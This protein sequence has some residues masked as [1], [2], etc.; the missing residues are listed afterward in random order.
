MG[1]SGAS[2]KTAPPAQRRKEWSQKVDGFCY[3]HPL[4]EMIILGAVGDKRSRF[5]PGI[6]SLNI[7]FTPAWPAL[8]RRNAHQGRLAAPVGS[9]QA[10][11]AAPFHRQVH[12]LQGGNTGVALG[13]LNRLQDRGKR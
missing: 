10:D 9:E 11:N 12:P 8:P 2:N 5:R 6:H 7:Y 4:V 1:E 13:Q 3:V